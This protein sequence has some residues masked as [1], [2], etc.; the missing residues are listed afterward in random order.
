MRAS[1]LFIFVLTHV[2]ISLWKNRFCLRRGFGEHSKK[3][4]LRPSVALA[5]EDTA[6]YVVILDPRSLPCEMN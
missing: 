6:S 3:F 4:L 5:E 1:A 2:P